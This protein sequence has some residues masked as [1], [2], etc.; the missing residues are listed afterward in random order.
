MELGVLGGLIASEQQNR[1]LLH[2]VT[3]VDH[4]LNQLPQRTDC[5]GTGLCLRIR[6]RWQRQ[7]PFQ[8]VESLAAQLDCG[9]AEAGCEGLAHTDELKVS[10]S[11]A[12]DWISVA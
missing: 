4:V 2:G 5:G 6:P 7:K 11:R 3:A 10:S 1:L 9:A 12:I 8:A